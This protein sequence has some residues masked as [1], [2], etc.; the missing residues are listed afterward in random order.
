MSESTITTASSDAA[1]LTARIVGEGAIGLSPATKLF[2][3]GRNGRRKHPSTLTR[4]SHVGVRRRDGVVVRL[5]TI[6][7]GSQLMTSEK[8]VLRFIAALQEDAPNN[9]S[10][11]S[12]PSPSARSRAQAAATA[13]LDALGVK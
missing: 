2:G 9:T 7:V 3:T 4:Y 8:A 12:P 6:R 10:S 1:A 13:E 5:E 11:T